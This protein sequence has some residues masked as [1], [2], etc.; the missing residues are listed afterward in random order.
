[1]N[2]A[3]KSLISAIVVAGLFG[4]SSI[5]SAQTR[6]ELR[7]RPEPIVPETPRLG[8]HGHF[9]WGYGMVVDHVHWGTPASRIGLEHGD[10][11]LSINGRRLRGEWDYFRALRES[12]GYVRLVIQD[13]RSGGLVAR[14]TFVGGSEYYRSDRTVG[15]ESRR[16]RSESTY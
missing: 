14:T 15:F 6:A 16:T 5:A 2:S 11:I 10:V 8:F 3:A 12:G 1:M 4:I 9:E 7:L 13:V